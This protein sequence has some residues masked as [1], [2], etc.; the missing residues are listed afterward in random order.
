M[1]S[2]T[3][4][5]HHWVI[6]DVHGCDAALERLLQQLPQADRLVFCG[7]VINRGPGIGAC[8]ERA[9][10]LVQS[11]RAVWL[12]GNH[13]QE[14]VEALQRGSWRA[15]RGLAGC[16]TY[17]HL[18]DRLCRAWLERLDHLPLAYWGDGWVATHAGFDPITWQP[19]LSIRMAFWEHYDGRFGPVVIGHTPGPRVRHLRHIV[20]VDTGACYGGLL[21]AYCPE[22][23]QQVSVPG[24][25]PGDESR[26]LEPWSDLARGTPVLAGDRRGRP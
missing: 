23:G 18:G 12:K 11:G 20:M 19:H 9:W 3:S 16:D 4:R 6:G 2:P 1:A 7:D 10:G 21:S 13:E 14:L 22:T 5:P 17:R 24:L 25:R 26:G 8:M 15:Q